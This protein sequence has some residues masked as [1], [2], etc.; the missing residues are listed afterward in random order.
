[1]M[2]KKLF[3]FVGGQLQLEDNMRSSQVFEMTIADFMIPK[4]VQMHFKF[5]HS[6]TISSARVDMPESKMKE[7]RKAMI[8]CGL[9]SICVKDVR[10]SYLV[11]AFN[12]I[13]ARTSHWRNGRK[14]ATYNNENIPTFYKCSDFQM[15][16]QP[17]VSKPSE[18]GDESDL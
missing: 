6:L 1:M 15:P 17:T 3:I 2:V 16:D 14:R 7:F 5:H 8:Y 11:A 18:N 4:K 10:K 12:A 9:A 13:N